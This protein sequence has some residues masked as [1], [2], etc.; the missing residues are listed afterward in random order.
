MPQ[1]IAQELV[2]VQPMTAAAG[3]AFTMNA[4]YWRIRPFIVVEDQSECKQYLGDLVVIDA[5]PKTTQW[6]LDQPAHMWKPASSSSDV[7]LAYTRFIIDKKL[8]TLM[9]LTF[10]VS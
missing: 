9:A 5:N 8:L 1:M 4:E 10:D 6:I 7:R 2:G 3:K